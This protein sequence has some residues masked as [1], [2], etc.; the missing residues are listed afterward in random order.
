V[1]PQAKIEHMYDTDPL[2]ELRDITAGLAAMASVDFAQEPVGV[3]NDTVR[4]WCAAFSALQATGA[5]L[6]AAWD[7]QCGWADDAAV[8]GARWLR[9]YGEMEHG[10]RALKVARRLRDWTG[11]LPPPRR[12]RPACCRTPRPRS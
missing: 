9:T 4:D 11:R 7:G 10:A 1:F 2:I 3:L 6:L 12:W 5:K 8:N